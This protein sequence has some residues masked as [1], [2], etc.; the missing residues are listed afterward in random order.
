[1]VNYIKTA[2]FNRSLAGVY[3]LQALRLGDKLTDDIPQMISF[4]QWLE[5]TY[6]NLEKNVIDDLKALSA[7]DLI[8]HLK[9]ISGQL[10]ERRKYKNTLAPREQMR[11]DI[12]IKEFSFKIE[13][14]AW[15]RLL[16]NSSS[17][18]IGFVELN[19]AANQVI[20][21]IHDRL[22]P[23]HELFKQLNDGLQGKASKVFITAIVDVLQKF[24]NVSLG[25]NFFIKFLRTLE[26][27]PSILTVNVEM[28]QA[29]FGAIAPEKK[30]V[31]GPI[32]KI[33]IG[34]NDDLRE[35]FYIAERV[36]IETGISES[37]ITANFLRLANLLYPLLTM[38]REDMKDKLLGIPP[39][40]L[41]RVVS[42]VIFARQLITQ[43]DK[44]DETSTIAVELQVEAALNKMQLLIFAP[45]YK[46]SSDNIELTAENMAYIARAENLITAV[47][48]PF[49]AEI[50]TWCKKNVSKTP[51]VKKSV[52]QMQDEM[53][54][55]QSKISGIKDGLRCKLK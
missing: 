10:I 41:E 22:T 38:V 7:H 44:K 5:V 17:Q 14:P 18:D 4:L 19:K 6:V 12:I 9:E 50:Q 24:D 25:K 27:I 46:V 20:Q 15:A 34:L 33:L 43:K 11:P 54:N 53:K 29:F 21:N 51:D 8:P 55:F 52:D 49:C 37:S 36:E 45:L 39:Y 47:L 16:R 23:L 13:L 26:L 42:L 28:A 31:K 40:Y 1:M 2:D 35:M 3:S 30:D 48:I 32:Q